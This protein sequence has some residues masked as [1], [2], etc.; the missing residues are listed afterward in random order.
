MFT[1]R[2]CRHGRGGRGA[3]VGGGAAAVQVG[4]DH[5]PLA[6]STKN[7]LFIGKLL[8]KYFIAS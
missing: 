7:I 6:L 5:F 4:R 2:T 3:G 1:V 8:Q